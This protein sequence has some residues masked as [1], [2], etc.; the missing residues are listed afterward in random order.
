MAATCMACLQDPKQRLT[1]PKVMKH[2]WVTKRGQ[3]PLRTVRETVR[4]GDA[5]GADD[6][7]PDMPDFMSTL[8]VLDIP[9]AVCPSPIPQTQ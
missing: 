5:I 4:A 6:E 3:W 9:R 1:M 7:E 8:N 2:P